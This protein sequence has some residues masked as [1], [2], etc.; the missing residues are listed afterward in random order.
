MQINS[1]AIQR[2]DV[3]ATSPLLVVIHHIY[4]AAQAAGA[5]F[6]PM[7]PCHAA[8][9]TSVI[10][11]NKAISASQKQHKW[12]EPRPSNVFSIMLSGFPW[13]N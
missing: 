6:K 2:S 7:L 5:A 10:A 4:S 11:F 13:F 1:F 9:L 12:Q 3:V 8:E